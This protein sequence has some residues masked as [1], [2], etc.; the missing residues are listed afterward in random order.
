MATSA[1]SGRSKA[2]GSG[3]ATTV[4]GFYL[5]YPS[6]SQRSP[7]LQLFVETL[8]EFTAK[9]LSSSSAKRTR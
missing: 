2:W 7:A 5:Y 3:Y 6:R 1:W 4:P 8:R 9:Q